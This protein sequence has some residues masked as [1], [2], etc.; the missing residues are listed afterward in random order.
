MS[1][2]LLLREPIAPVPPEPEIPVGAGERIIA[3]GPAV[4]KLDQRVSASFRVNREFR[5][6]LRAR[7]RVVR[8]APSPQLFSARLPGYVLHARQVAFSI[9]AVNAA[10][11][12]YVG[13]A[14]EDEDLLLTL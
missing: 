10:A 5:Q 12:R 14:R 9:P 6:M 2:L 3:A 7:F 1:L 11:K 13:L 4:I 8:E